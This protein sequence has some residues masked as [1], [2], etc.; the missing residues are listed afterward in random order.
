V[1][2]LDVIID[3]KAVRT[4]PATSF[5]NHAPKGNRAIAGSQL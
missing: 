4:G 1:T 2:Y 5:G 3:N